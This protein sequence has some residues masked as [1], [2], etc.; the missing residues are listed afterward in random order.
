[1]YA[2]L[3]RTVEMTSPTLKKATAP[4]HVPKPFRLLLPE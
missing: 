1:M 2:W 3:Y 4:S